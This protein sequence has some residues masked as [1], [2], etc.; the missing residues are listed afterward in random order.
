MEISVRSA[1]LFGAAPP[2]RAEGAVF[3]LAT[4]FAEHG[5]TVARWVRRLGGADID[6]DDAVQEIFLVAH[7]RLR[8]F[9]VE[10]RLKAW[11]FRTTAAIVRN[12]RRRRG[13]RRL[14]RRDLDEVDLPSASPTPLEALEQSRAVAHTHRLL[15]RLPDKHR[16][17]LVLFE[18]E[19]R[20][21]EE[22]AG[23]M[24]CKLATVWVWLH[25]ARARFLQLQKEGP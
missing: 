7:R 11:L 17:V 16:A 2:P 8:D 3:D 13:W 15:Q 12:H 24:G 14:F 23:M 5:Q 9:T 25:R 20:S 21:G 6:V 18:V 22:I 19:G 10:A 4:L 1:R